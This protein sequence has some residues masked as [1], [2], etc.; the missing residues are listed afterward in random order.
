MASIHQLRVFLAAYEL[1]SLT[2]AAARLG[3]AQPTVSE[4]VRLLERSLGARLFERVG[5]GLVP[6]EAA[7]ALRPHAEQAVG[8]VEA[9]TRA[10]RSVNQLE[11]GTLRFGVF[12]ASRIYLGATIVLEL[13]RRH[14]GVRVELVGRHSTDV[15]DQLRRGH[16]EAAATALPVDDP[17]LEIH[18]VFNDELVYVSAH[19]DR[20]ASPV[21]AAR[22]GQAPL[23][24][25]WASWANDPT[26]AALATLA[27]SA[28]QTLKSRVEVEDL[29]TTVDLAA[30]GEADTVLSLGV[31]HELGDRVPPNLGWAPIRPRQYDRFAIVH[32]RDAVLSPATRLM[33]ELVTT[34][35]LEVHRGA[36]ALGRTRAPRPR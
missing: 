35:L 29:E 16:M 36:R 5:R 2:A 26:R 23:A 15:V 28:G 34:R 4:Q 1:G 22:L 10:V 13:L 6:T 20:V 27:E 14:P 11:S 7:H 12:G 9:A 30:A 8:S 3:Y 18:P 19:P 21:T 32:R 31:L 17:T 33:V 24:L 25:A